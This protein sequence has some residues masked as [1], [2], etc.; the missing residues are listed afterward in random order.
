METKE[1]AAARG[2]GRALE[3]FEAGEKLAST[4]KALRQKA[5]QTDLVR[6]LEVGGKTSGSRQ[7]P[8]A[9][10]GTSSQTA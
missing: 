9:A 6:E 5:G 4:R 8:G 3:I 7:S 2:R 1:E 10:A